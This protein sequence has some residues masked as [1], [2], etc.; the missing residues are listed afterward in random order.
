MDR[1][2]KRK[3]LSRPGDAPDLKKMS[4]DCLAKDGYTMQEDD[5]L[6]T[7]PEVADYLRVAQITIYKWVSAGRI[8]VTH[9]G[10]NVRFRVGDI[11]AFVAENTTERISRRRAKRGTA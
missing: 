5:R 11:R 7:V 6:L 3:L 1:G 4:E 8:T 2:S 9:A 10:R